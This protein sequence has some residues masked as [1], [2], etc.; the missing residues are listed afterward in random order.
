M[1]RSD[2]RFPMPAPT[3]RVWA[4]LA[5][6]ERFPDLWPW[7]RRFDGTELR[8]G[9][10]WS[11]AVQPPVPYLVRF[12]IHL[13]EVDDGRRIAAHV[14]GDVRGDAE[15]TLEG[16]ATGCE[17]HLTAA[18]DPAATLLRGML[19]IAP[20]IARFGHDWILDTGAR[21]FR[22]RAVGGR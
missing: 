18:L 22:E 5:R 11:C 16:D 2:R 13:D 1:I 20:P 12:R 17:L 10:T 21:Q 9:A 19:T 14:D 6:P 4:A 8:R 7:L 15:L 3:E